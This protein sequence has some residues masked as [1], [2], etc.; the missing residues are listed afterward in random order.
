MNKV[1]DSVLWD[2]GGHLQILV[3][4][5]MNSPKTCSCRTVA[6][7]MEVGLEEE[8]VLPQ[9]EMSL[10]KL[11]KHMGSTFFG[12]KTPMGDSV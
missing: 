2:V 9:R 11:L 6:K 12:N 7:R 5:H 8:H 4:K 3:P 1:T 10:S